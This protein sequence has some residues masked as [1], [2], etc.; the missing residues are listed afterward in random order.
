[1]KL[2]EAEEKPALEEKMNWEKLKADNEQ[3]KARIRKLKAKLNKIV[4]VSSSALLHKARRRT[5]VTNTE[6]VS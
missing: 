5:H 3:Y 4:E 6:E 2:K 1:M